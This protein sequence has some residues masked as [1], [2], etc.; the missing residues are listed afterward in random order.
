MT[1][2][3]AFLQD[4]LAHP[5][6][7]SPRLIFA[8][9]LEEQ[10]DV[11][12]VAR[13]EFIRVQCALAA[14]QLLEAQRATLQRREQQLLSTWEDKWVRPI[15]RLVR[16][17][18]FHRGF[19]DNIAMLADKF[20]TNGSRVFRRAPIQHLCLWP[21]M[22]PRSFPEVE[23]I[24]IAVFADNKCL[25]NLLSLD[26]SD[27]QLGSSHVRALIVSE[28]LGRL[29]AL[30]LSHNRIGDGG[31]RALA[32]SRLLSRLERLNLCGNDIGAGGLRALARALGAFADS[33]QGIRLQRLELYRDS[34][35]TSAQLVIAES[36]VLRR[37][38]RG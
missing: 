7:D 31:I 36:P 28:H 24:N 17:W 11:E 23:P 27:N 9:W 6:D 35:S 38:V 3:D 29:T 16:N 25:N 19:I 30:D 8:D 5:D 32:G 21:R 18:G 1:P 13:A 2:A 14:G 15:R 10:G 37:L 4:I 34:L 22:Y 12:S 20:F 26:L 33:P